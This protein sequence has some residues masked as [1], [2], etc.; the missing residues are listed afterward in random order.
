MLPEHVTRK[1]ADLRRQVKHD[2]ETIQAS[3]DLKFDAIVDL[4]TEAIVHEGPFQE[5]VGRRASKPPHGQ[6]TQYEVHTQNKF[7]QLPD[8]VTES[9]QSESSLDDDYSSKQA[10]DSYMYEFGG[11]NKSKNKH[12]RQRDNTTPDI[13]LARGQDDHVLA[14]AQDRAGSKRSIKNSNETQAKTA[15]K[16]DKQQVPPAPQVSPYSLPTQFR[17]NLLNYFT[18]NFNNSRDM[19]RDDKWVTKML[20]E[21]TDTEDDKDELERLSCLFEQSPSGYATFQLFTSLGIQEQN[22]LAH[23]FFTARQNIRD[24]MY[25]AY[26][27]RIKANSPAPRPGILPNR[28]ESN[29]AV[30]ATEPSPPRPEMSTSKTLPNL[31]RADSLIEMQASDLSEPV[32][33]SWFYN[34]LKPYSK[35]SLNKANDEEWVGRALQVW[36]ALTPT[37]RL[38]MLFEETPSGYAASLLWKGIA[39]QG[40]LTS[41]IAWNETRTTLQIDMEHILKERFELVREQLESQGTTQPGSAPEAKTT[42]REAI[43]YI[44]DGF[45]GFESRKDFVREVVRVA[46]GISFS[47]IHKLDKG[48]I[49]VEAVKDDRNKADELF[50]K[51]G[52]PSDAFGGGKVS[53]HRPGDGPRRVDPKDARKVVIKNMDRSL[54]PLDT[55]E[56]FAECGVEVEECYW[57][58]PEGH[59]TGKLGVIFKSE[60][61]ARQAKGNG[62]IVFYHCTYPCE[63]NLPK[64]TPLRCYNCNGFDH[65]ANTCKNP[66]TCLRCG[67]E[68][69]KNIDCPVQREEAAQ[70]KCSNCGGNHLAIDKKCPKYVEA[71]AALLARIAQK[72]AKSLKLIPAPLPHTS[73]WPKPKPDVSKICTE[74][75]ES[76]K[77]ALADGNEETAKKL[78]ED[79]LLT[80][81]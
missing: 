11:E 76:L 7:G 30:K 31:A 60:D 58:T 43:G 69:H 9:D 51:T 40:R 28:P 15:K 45:K 50:L 64:P 55:I 6:V 23:L 81:C 79:K 39:L 10:R 71:K 63:R 33:L 73:A 27:K 78:L 4:A 67:L 8:H 48:G 17:R 49:Y 42:P 65:V 2:I 68:G 72:T 46:P 53:C 41:M 70:F 19:R 32:D 61:V 24:E 74:L 35:I 26:E 59:K 66:V 56:M 22:G 52:L 38:H 14:Q 1:L 34:L 36:P 37:N 77:T 54:S 25:A 47:K 21:L 12:G 3:F 5:V 18:K 57:L 16:D 20:A 44:I 13:E 29:T 80:L 62:K 75:L